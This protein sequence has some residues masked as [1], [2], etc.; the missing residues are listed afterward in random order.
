MKVEPSGLKKKF[1]E[2]SR[3]YRSDYFL[4][5]PDK[6]RKE[7]MEKSSE[8]DAAFKIFQQP[9]ETIRYVLQLNGLWHEEEKYEFGP[10]FLVEVA[11]LNEQLIELELE[12]DEEKMAECEQMAKGLINE[13]YENV[14]KIIEYYQEGITSEKELLQ[15]KDY[16]YRKK[17]LQGILDRIFQIRNIASQF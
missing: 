17:Y 6:E 9:D 4:M 3:Q 10:D 1:Y 2:L 5:A 7:A 15:V 16:Y 11:D 12:R 13:N 14:A 8:V